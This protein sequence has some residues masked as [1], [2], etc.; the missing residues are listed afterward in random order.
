[1]TDEQKKAQQNY[2]DARKRIN[3]QPTVAQG[4]IRAET[5]YADAYQALVRAG[6]APQLKAKHRFTEVAH[7]R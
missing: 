3:L 6:L 1:M 2:E 4:A 7:R 5:K